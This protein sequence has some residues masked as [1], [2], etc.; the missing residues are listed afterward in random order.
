[1][2]T[3]Y[4]RAR[5]GYSR[6]A[7]GNVMAVYEVKNLGDEQKSVTLI[8]HH[9]YGSS[10]L[11]LEQKQVVIPVSGDGIPTSFRVET[12][13][14]LN[15]KFATGLGG[16]TKTVQ[17][18]LEN[19][20]KKLRAKSAKKSY[21]VFK[22]IALE[23]GRVNFKIKI[24][25]KNLKTVTLRILGLTDA[26]LYVSKNL[27]KGNNTVTFNTAID[28][29]YKI[30]ITAKKNNNKSSNFTIDN[31][32][33]TLSKN[34]PLI[35]QKHSN[36]IGDKRY[37]L[38]NHLGNV[39]SVVTDNQIVK[40][41]GLVPELILFN[42][43]NTSIENWK[44]TSK[45]S[46]NLAS[47]NNRLSVKAIK[48]GGGMFLKVTLEASHKYLV[49]L[50]VNKGE[51]INL[52]FKINRGE[53]LLFN[54][55]IVKASQYV[56]IEPTQT[57]T[58]AFKV[59]RAQ[60]KKPSSLFFS[61]DNFK[62]LDVTGFTEQQI[63]DIG[64]EEGYL[65]ADVVAYNDYYPF[66]MLLPNRHHNTPDYRYGFQGQEMDDEVKGE[67]NSLNYKYR[68][69]DPRVGR[70][71]AVDP[72]AAKYPYNSPYVFSEN[73]LIDSR[74]LEGLE[75]INSTKYKI[76]KGD[77]FNGLESEYDLGEGMLQKLNPSQNPTKLQ[78]GQLIDFATNNGN[79]IVVPD[80][81]NGKDDRLPYSS[82]PEFSDDLDLGK[83]KRGAMMFGVLLEG[84]K[85]I[86]T[87]ANS[88]LTAQVVYL[89]KS[90]FSAGKSLNSLIKRAGVKPKFEYSK[91][92]T[93]PAYNET[94]YYQ[95]ARAKYGGEKYLNKWYK[96]GELLPHSHPR[97]LFFQKQI[98]QP[99]LS[100]PSINSVQ[101]PIYNLNMSKLQ[102]TGAV[103]L[104][105]G[106]IIYSSNDGDG[107]GRN[108]YIDKL[109]EK[110]KKVKSE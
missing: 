45:N 33:C 43:F 84:P 98:S 39:L 104:E 12:N 19:V 62:I 81:F 1:M 95:Q 30:I 76:Q 21:G 22:K 103:I 16:W 80:S 2:V 108:D 63:A 69:H 35:V 38:S 34:I 72:L 57:A 40:V 71:F 78:I 25:R 107:N 83:Q 85:D 100:V 18:S 97:H 55:K 68:M 32:L 74:E 9:I 50:D 105:A 75:K 31:V 4:N 23:K 73:R 3:R 109:G 110:K 29:D 14:L 46:T 20:K 44:K 13:T 79:M 37:E 87:V 89:P 58:H 82:T 66:G 91:S 99:I 106:A 93:E 64:N 47:V 60:K 59:Y 7:Q 51:F 54:Q 94:L 26:K 86:V 6:D 36:I 42:D 88:Y 28:Q 77:T 90:I 11:G 24:T 10:R 102:Y 41:D 53:Q 48:K 101:V 5:A 67:G 15:Q 56:L 61:I 52:K 49:T 8:E 92:I 17:I 96:N 70:F 27:I 65:S